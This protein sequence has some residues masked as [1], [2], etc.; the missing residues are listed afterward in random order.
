MP[1]P[2]LL[3]A[4]AFHVPS[5]ASGEAQA[6]TRIR[7]ADETARPYVR[8]GGGLWLVDTGASRTT[9]DDSY[10]RGS[11]VAPS[12]WRARGEAGI[13]G[14]G[15]AVLRDVDVGG[16]HFARLP[17]AVRDLDSTSSLPPGAA[18]VLG[19]NVLRHF[20]VEFTDDDVTLSTTRVEGERLRRWGVRL[21]ATLSVDGVDVPVVVDTG[22]DHAYLPLASAHP[23]QVYAAVREGT[24]PSGEVA[25]E[26]IVHTVGDARVGDLDLPLRT[27]IEREGRIGLLGIDAFTGRRVVVDFVGR[28]LFVSP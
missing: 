6:L 11:R 25:V 12:P 13:V 21:V 4:C 24:G 22:A 23:V 15:R 5:P 3:L 9:C 26:V 7:D 27:W 8:I 17:C 10:V 19:S 1:V 2:W 16:W 28:R 14:V 20:S 18:G